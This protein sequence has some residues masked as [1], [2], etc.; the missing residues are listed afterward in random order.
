M[1]H[2]FLLIL[3]CLIIP[4]SVSAQQQDLKIAARSYLLSD[5]QTGQVLAGQMHER[6]EP[7]SLTKLDDGLRGILGSKAESDFAG[8]DCSGIGERLAHDWLS[9]VYRT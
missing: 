8:A 5:F 4:S 6:I 7:A 9:H 2:L 1:K 3:V